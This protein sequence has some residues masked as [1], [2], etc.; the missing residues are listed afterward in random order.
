VLDSKVTEPPD[1]YSNPLV[2]IHLPDKTRRIHD[3]ARGVGG[4]VVQSDQ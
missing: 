2:V 4:R 1:L 3:L